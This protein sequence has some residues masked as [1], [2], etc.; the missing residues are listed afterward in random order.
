[1][2]GSGAPLVRTPPWLSHLDLEWR[3][4]PVREFYEWLARKHT[5]VRYDSQGC[6]LSE[7]KRSD[8][9]LDSEVRLLDEVVEKLRL[10]RFT[11]FGH[12][13]GALIAIKYA[14]RHPERV[15]ALAL[16]G[17]PRIFGRRSLAEDIPECFQVLIRDHWKLAARLITSLAAPSVDGGTIE[18]LS[19]A[20][21]R[22]STG[23]NVLESICAMVYEADLGDLSSITA[24]AAIIHRAGD[25]IAPYAS[26]RELAARIPG[27][28]LIPVEGSSDLPY[29][30]NTA[31][32]LQA[33]DEAVDRATASATEAADA[34][35]DAENDGQRAVFR[36][37]GEYWTVAFRQAPFRIRDSQGMRYIAQ[38]LRNPDREFHARELELRSGPVE[39]P[40]SAPGAPGADREGSAESGF[41][42][43]G[44]GDLGAMLD[45]RAKSAYRRRLQEL[46]SDLDHARAAGNVE[47]A[48]ELE[49]EISFLARELSQA[50]GLRGRD[51][52]AGS[53]AER[54]RINVTRAIHRAIE[55]IGEHDEALGELLGSQIKTG[56]LCVYR[57]DDSL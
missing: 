29:V 23:R 4:P 10:D 34:A 24:P 53:L 19:D 55:R 43:H 20:A 45:A 6:G 27:S 13:I 8:F 35:G 7:W 18:M 5:V 16:F 1:V 56:L 40:G 54:S 38:L 2:I 39:T 48:A 44:S 26:A 22:S 42:M 57:P 50:V 28:W 36:S 30:G 15:A 25:R 9:S 31:P 37:E 14:V 51:R 41:E 12:N 11:L 17:T 33:I 32:V 46:R 21:R 3:L 47:R 52:R 49:N